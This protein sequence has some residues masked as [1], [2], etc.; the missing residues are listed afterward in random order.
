[1]TPY[2]SRLVEIIH[3]HSST[4]IKILISF[5]DIIIFVYNIFTPRFD[6]AN[7]DLVQYLTMLPIT[8]ITINASHPKTFISKTACPVCTIESANECKKW[9]F[10]GYFVG[11]SLMF[12]MKCVSFTQNK[13]QV[14]S[15]PLSLFK[16]SQIWSNLGFFNF[17]SRKCKFFKIPLQIRNRSL[18]GF[19]GQVTLILC[20]LRS[21]LIFPGL[22]AEFPSSAT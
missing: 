5:N 1:M 14:F 13:V 20:S 10:R 18:T 11:I 4:F 16:K 3:E 9:P 19:W 8:S 15:H 17:L 6:L 2:Y 22:I 7:L 21:I 12:N